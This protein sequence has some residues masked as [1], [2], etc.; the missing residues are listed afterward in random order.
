MKSEQPDQPDMTLSHWFLVKL[1]TPDGA[2]CGEWIAN[3]YT[4]AYVGQ[5]LSIC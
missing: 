1:Y 3:P 5:R 2:L 4:G